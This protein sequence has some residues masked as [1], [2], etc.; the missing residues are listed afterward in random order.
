MATDQSLL[1]RFVISQFGAAGLDRAQLIRDTGVPDWSMSGNDVHL[2]SATFSRLWEVG[3]HRLG[4][5]VALQVA[6]RYELS[7]LGLYD[8]LFASAP[9][10]GSGLATCGPY[11]T[12]VTT[13]HRFDLVAETEEESTLYLEMIDGEG[14]GRDHTQLWGLSAVLS[15][16]RRVVDATLNP[17]RVSLR[18]AAPAY[19]EGF[20][21]VFGSATLEFDAPADSMTFRTSDLDLPLTTADPVLAAVLQ[22]LAAALAPPPTLVS[23]WPRRVAE[24]LDHAIEAGE[25]SLDS[26]A[27][28]LTV[29]PRTLQ[30]RLT[31]S[32]TTWRAEL[33]RA[34]S[35]RLSQAVSAGSLSGARQ[36]EL[37]GYSDAG[38]L[39]RAARRW[40]PASP[41]IEPLTS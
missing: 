20:R 27:R 37:L 30:R 32:G 26:V 10:L 19:V 31:E 18:Q 23:A 11:I 3:E 33:D 13:N 25:V 7:S 21:A 4:E 36:A 16:A 8:Y 22:P 15:R 38:S 14:R 40:S 29:S 24:A 17:V 39:R 12:A 2:P 9:T 6:Q 34:R 5:D 28:A 41:T 35:A 1:H